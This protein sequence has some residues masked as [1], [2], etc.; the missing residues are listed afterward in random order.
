MRGLGT[1]AWAGLA[2]LAVSV[3]VAAPTLFGAAEPAI[4]RVWWVVLFAVFLAA[5]V[6]GTASSARAVR[7][8][9]FGI[10][11]AAAW[12]VVLTAQ[13]TGLLLILLVITAAVAAYVVPL[14]IGMA[15]VLLNT[16]VVALVATLAGSDGVE[17]LINTGFYLLIQSA[18][19]LSSV[20]LI[21]EQ[22]LR[23]ELAEA[24]VELQA[25]S[26]MLS[27]SARTA[28]RLRISR[29]LHDVI[30][31][32]LTVLTLELETARHLDGEA[33]RGHLERADR[34]ARDLLR[35]VRETVGQLR[36]QAPDLEHALHEMT[37]ALPGLAVT[38][39][40][41]GDVRPTEEQSAALVRAAQEIVTNTLRHAEAR[42]LWIEVRAD[43][44]GI[45][46][47]ARDDGRGAREVVLGN[48]LRGLRERF[49][50]LGGDVVVDG[51]D[52]F[53]VTARLAPA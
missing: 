18:A 32:Q 43:R 29:E 49:A 40:V 47:R 31:H 3:G 50:E 1:E 23:A 11:V 44:G 24:H 30:G 25:A 16:G 21:R 52:G 13:N 4:P 8:G 37:R 53:R 6:V 51:S 27:E 17:L 14:R 39:D 38:V 46:L 12:A 9:G 20:T 34:V 45:V 19:L 7:F 42:E 10:A 36:T 41:A 28:E 15:V 35:D 26:V 48:G 22:R 33:A 2:M 5:I